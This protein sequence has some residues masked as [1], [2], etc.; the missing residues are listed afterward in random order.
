[1]KFPTITFSKRTAALAFISMLPVDQKK[2]I[3]NQWMNGYIPDNQRPKYLWRSIH[4]RLLPCTKPTEF[5]D[6]E[7]VQYLIQEVQTHLRSTQHKVALDR[8]PR[9]TRRIVMA[10]T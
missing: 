3:D 7:G 8:Y 6:E 10:G 9:E 4:S 1:M 2:G 5:D